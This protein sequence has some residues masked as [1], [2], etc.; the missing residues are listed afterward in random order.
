MTYSTGMKCGDAMNKIKPSAQFI[1][2]GNVDSESDFNK[3]EWVTGADEN[4]DAITTTT[5]PHSE[6][7][8]TAV[9]AEMDKL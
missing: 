9:K 4:E 2:R 1:I 6:L 8:W 5:N 7:T 3:I